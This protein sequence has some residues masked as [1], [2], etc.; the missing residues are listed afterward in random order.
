MVTILVIKTTYV[1]TDIIMILLQITVY[2]PLKAISINQ[3]FYTH[4]RTSLNV[5]ILLKTLYTCII[6]LK[7]LSCT[8]PADRLVASESRG[9]RKQKLLFKLLKGICHYSIKSCVPPLPT[10]YWL[11]NISYT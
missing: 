1:C 8:C 7:E 11:I 4:F 9:Q 5:L 3:E 6:V 2:I 10:F